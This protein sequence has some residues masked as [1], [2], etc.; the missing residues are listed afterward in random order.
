MPEHHVKVSRTARYFTIGECSEKTRNVWI[1]CHGYGQ[2]A[3]YFIRNFESLTTQGDTLIVA[4]EALSRF[5]LAGTGGRVGATWMT[6][7][8]RLHEITDY[9][10]YLD[11]LLLTIS[12]PLPADVKVFVLGF[13]QGVDRKSVV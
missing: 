9:L 10:D 12:Q 2:L 7:E 3:S 6:R 5:Y 11:T 4:P 8:D 13:S 1:V